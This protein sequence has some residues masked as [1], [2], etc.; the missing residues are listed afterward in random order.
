MACELGVQVR[1]DLDL[2]RQAKREFWEEEMVQAKARRC[3][4]DSLTSS[5]VSLGG[6]RMAKEEESLLPSLFSFSK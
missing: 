2:E 3:S 4:G 5:L 6:P 1:Q